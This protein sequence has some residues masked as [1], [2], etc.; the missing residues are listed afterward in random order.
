MTG[1]PADRRETRRPVADVDDDPN[2]ADRG[3]SSPP[4]FMHEVDPA[5]TGHMR[6]GEVVALL[7]LL[8]EAERAGAKVTRAMAGEAT[9]PEA[10]RVLAGIAGD[11]A[12][13]C[14][15]LARHVERLGGTPSPKTGAFREKVMALADE[16]AR[17]ALLDRGQAW[18]VR[19]IAESLPRLQDDSLHADLAEMLEVHERNLARSGGLRTGG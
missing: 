3:F 1:S 5:W 18:V 9:S 16:G 6:T 17:L 8:L 14:A 4:C 12:R 7:N 19:K 15:M 2:V 11:E 10:H 13:F